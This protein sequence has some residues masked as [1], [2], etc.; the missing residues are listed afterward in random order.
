M[1]NLVSMSTR[2]AILDAAQRL[3][4]RY[5]YRKTT[6]DE[7]AREAGIA[8][9]TVYLYFKSKEEIAVGRI[10]R[11]L[12]SMRV[13]L[14]GIASSAG[15]PLDRLRAVLIDRVMFRVDS[16]QLY[17]TDI[18]TLLGEIRPALAVQRQE[19][20]RDETAVVRRL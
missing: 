20:L 5:G 15:S 19:F 2:D 11:V 17:A 6:V 12:E 16:A 10:E 14:E 18:E 4:A 9:G 1:T 13:R 8:K 3:F 7:L